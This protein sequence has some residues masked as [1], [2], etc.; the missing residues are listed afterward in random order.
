MNLVD[1]LIWVAVVVAIVS[2]WAILYARPQKEI[3]RDSFTQFDDVDDSAL[4]SVY[5][6]EVVYQKPKKLRVRPD[7]GSVEEAA[8]MVTYASLRSIRKTAK[9]HRYTYST[10]RNTLLAAGVL[11]RGRGRRSQK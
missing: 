10:T 6:Y 9:R 7:P 11:H 4:N 2:W 1:I 3:G 8:L 5:T